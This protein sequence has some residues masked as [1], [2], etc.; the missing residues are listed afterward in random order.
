MAP[1]ADDPGAPQRSCGDEPPT[2]TDDDEGR[3]SVIPTTRR[4]RALGDPYDDPRPLGPERARHAHRPR[5]RPAAAAHRRP[6]HRAARPRRRR[7]TSARTSSPRRRRRPGGP[8]LPRRDA[9]PLPHPRGV[10]APSPPGTGTSTPSPASCAAP[11]PTVRDVAAARRALRLPAAAP[12]RRPR[13]LRPRTGPPHAPPAPARRPPR[14]PLPRLGRVPLRG[15]DAAPAG[16]G[17]AARGR[18]TTRRSP[19][20]RDLA[21]LKEAFERTAYARRTPYRVEAPFQLTLAGRVIRGR[22]DAVYR[23]PAPTATACEI[24]DWKTGRTGTADPLQLAVYRLAWAERHGLC[25]S[26][27]ST[28]P[29]STSAAAESSDPQ[30]CPAGRS[31]SASC[32]VRPTAGPPPEGR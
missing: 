19:T 15:A 4:P 5:H 16:P 29:S 3:S 6:A 31:W 26:R 20:K 11:A 18:R 25:R 2:P 17:R 7:P 27:R 8:A 24:V 10:A 9:T 23:T 1:A 22:I 12:R 28:P 21:A 32:S 13:R 14:H 30:G